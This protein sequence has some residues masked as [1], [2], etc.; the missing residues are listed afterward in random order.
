M[1]KIRKTGF[2]KRMP[3]RLAAIGYLTRH[4]AIG[5]VCRYLTA[6]S[7]FGKADFTAARELVELFSIEAEELTEAGVP[8]ETVKALEARCFIMRCF[9][10]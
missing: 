5:R 6:H 4:E 1:R 8:F 7:D 2:S 3:D 10:S 9:R